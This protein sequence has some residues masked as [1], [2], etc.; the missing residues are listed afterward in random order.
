MSPVGPA[1]ASHG[2]L[3]AFLSDRPGAAGHAVP[4][5]E[6]ETLCGRRWDWL[7]L[8]YPGSLSAWPAGVPACRPCLTRVAKELHATTCPAC[9]GSLVWGRS[10]KGNM[11]Q[12]AHRPTEERRVVRCMHDAGPFT[13]G[14]AV[15][16][17]LPPTFDGLRPTA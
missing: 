13:N 5:G 14:R 17:L 12:L 9:G 16:P 7:G 2:L 4:K 10:R 11:V 15:T 6:S 8:D 3:L 1:A